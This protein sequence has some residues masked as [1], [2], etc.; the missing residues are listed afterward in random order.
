MSMLDDATGGRI[1]NKLDKHSYL[2]I[3]ANFP[4][5]LTIVLINYSTH[6]GYFG[7]IYGSFERAYQI[8]LLY[9]FRSKLLLFVLEI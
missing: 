5:I 8:V 1:S 6:R 4:P 7:L 2:M 3:V 9:L